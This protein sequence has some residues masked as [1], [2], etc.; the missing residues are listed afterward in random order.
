MNTPSVTV[1]VEGDTDVPVVEKI[2]KLANREI[3]PIHGRTGKSRLDQQLPGYN[4]AAKYAPWLVLRDLDRDE[5]CAG[6]LVARLLPTS[7]PR[8]RLRIAVRALE[9][10]LLADAHSVSRYF[11]V[12]AAAITATPEALPDPKRT[13]VDLARKSRSS[14]VRRDMVPEQGMSARVGPGYS[15]RIIEFARDHWRPRV[16]AKRAPS[17]QRCIDAVRKLK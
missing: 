13:L 1:A 7:S 6:T 2:F 17:L 3:G 16:A 12:S 14:A 4:H 15:S 10:W 8:M 11:L 5:T 9:A